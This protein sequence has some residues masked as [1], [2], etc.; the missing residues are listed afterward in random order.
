M[1]LS[2]FSRI[3][4]SFSFSIII[5]LNI[6]LCFSYYFTET[7]YISNIKKN[8][9][10]Q[11]T[12]I[13]T[14]ININNSNILSLPLGQIRQVNNIWLFFNIQLS[15]NP[16]KTKFIM[17][18]NKLFFQ[19]YYHN[20]D[21]IIWKDLEDLSSMKKTF[22]K[23]AIYLNIF[24]VLLI[25]SFT[26][27]ITKITLKPLY[28]LVN[29]LNDYK[30]WENTKLIQ[31]NYWNKDIWKLINTVNKFI[32]SINNVYNSQKEFI[33]DTSHELKTP[34]MQINTNLDLLETKIEDKNTINKL[35]S[36]RQSTEYLNNLVSSLNF[37]LHNQDNNFIKERINI[38]EYLSNTIWKYENLAKEKWIKL[39]IN[40]YNNL[41]VESNEYYLDRLF[42]NLI[43]NAIFYN[44][45]NWKININI[46][47]DKVEIQD[48]WIWLT[49][50]EQN[51]IFNRFYR[52][53]DSWKLN[54]NGSWLGLAIVQKICSMFGWKI[55][56]DSIL[57]E[58]TTFTIK[59]K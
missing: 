4:I 12:T 27:F 3:F 2:L 31:N 54:P 15:Q 42:E 17:Q 41:I 56:V 21:I 8:I 34:L 18:N 49:K 10:S 45:E 22:I 16:I 9:Y 25:L 5:I 23:V 24:S 1:K 6:I 32:K 33:Q 14:F 7:T 55:A 19:T 38:Y 37:I 44:K 36:I 40:K 58:W 51:K 53:Q 26:Y 43:T 48:T 13:K 50:E 46:C 52:N 20:Y 47:K 59:F 28:Q 29:F 57:W 11:F 35:D 39:N 30:F